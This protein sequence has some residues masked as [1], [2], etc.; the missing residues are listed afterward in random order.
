MRGLSMNREKVAHSCPCACLPANSSGKLAQRSV[1]SPHNGITQLTARVASRVYSGACRG[2]L[3]K[4]RSFRAALGSELQEYISEDG[5]WRV[6]PLRKEEVPELASLQAE[7]FYEPLP[8]GALNGFLQYSFQAETLSVVRQ[9][10]KYTAAG[11]GD[12]MVM[13]VAEDAANP[14]GL[15]GCVDISI[16]TGKEELE[17]L[18]KQGLEQ[19]L[20]YSYVACMTVRAR[21]RR[22]GVASALLRAAEIQAGKWNQNYVLLHVYADNKVG[23]A[24]YRSAGYSQIHTDPGWLFLLGRRQR[25]LFAKSSIVRAP[26][27]VIQSISENVM[28]MWQR[29]VN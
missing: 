28:R 5:K 18:R 23:V 24:L 17:A 10:L 20:V 7:S 25:V 27:G 15:V 29:Q 2:F 16:Q 1:S 21:D 6:R 3:V 22:K 19:E 14:D 26:A 4:A 12:G 13:L 9:K 8:V 11:N